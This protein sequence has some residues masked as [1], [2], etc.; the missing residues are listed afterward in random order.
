MW[1]RRDFYQFICLYVAQETTPARKIV[2][3]GTCVPSAR[4]VNQ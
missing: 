4:T 1:I 2:N 3:N